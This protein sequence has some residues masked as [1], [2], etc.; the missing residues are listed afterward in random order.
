M[1]Q[2]H[3]NSKS[4]H[5]QHPVGRTNAQGVQEE[6]SGEIPTE[7]TYARGGRCK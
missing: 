2:G 1:Q 3:R 6:G 4:N 5:P 7:S